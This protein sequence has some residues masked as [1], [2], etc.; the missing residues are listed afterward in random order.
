MTE[1]RGFDLLDIFII[2]L[3]RKK[4]F[5]SLF[6]I[7]LILSYVAIYFLVQEEF[8]STSLIISSKQDSFTGMSSLIKN[9]SNLPFGLGGMTQSDEIDKYKTIIYSRTNLDKI[10]SEYNL[11]NDYNLESME[12]ARKILKSKIIAE[13]TR[14]EA[15]TVT[16]RANSPQKTVEINKFII[17]EL[18]DVIISLNV[19][20]ARDNR[21]FLADRYNEIKIN[22]ASAEDSLKKF[23]SK[24]GVLEIENQVKTSIEEYS[25]LEAELATRKIELDVLKKVLGE[26]SPQI[27]NQE[28][29]VEEFQNYLNRL[30]TG[31]IKNPVLMPIN[32][33]PTKAL[34]Y[35]RLLRD[36]KIY[37][38]ML[39]FIIPLYEQAKFDEQKEIP[40]LQVI[41]YPVEPEKKAY[42]PRTL[43]AFLIALSISLFTLL[44][45]VITELSTKSTNPKLIRIKNEFRWR[46]AIDN[47]IT[48]M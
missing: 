14:E 40:I 37:S 39:E 9:F 17:K 32:S 38:S 5:I 24:N 46:K 4:F 36:V 22:L 2:I 6:L 8:D 27:K 3:K 12:K 26:N 33:M 19:K 15:F 48:G 21:N 30:Q 18:N 29:S 25:K 28:I 1:N 16:V 44:Y 7:S 47:D 42:P 11:L 43:F 20:K 23:Q 10:I 35:L 34:D 45:F 13:E 31:N 41:D